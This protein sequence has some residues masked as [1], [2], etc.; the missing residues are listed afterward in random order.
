MV[1]FGKELRRTNRTNK[2]HKQ[3]TLQILEAVHLLKQV[4]VMHYKEHQRDM[5]KVFLG[6][7][8]VGGKPEG[9]SYST[10]IC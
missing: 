6:N 3:N 1:Q 4:E 9:Q 2:K 8:K 10:S 7:Q 5:S